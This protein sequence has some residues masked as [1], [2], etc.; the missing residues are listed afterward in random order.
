MALLL[1]KKYRSNKK[2]NSR[3]HAFRD[4]DD[5]FNTF[6]VDHAIIQLYKDHESLRALF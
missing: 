1:T 2:S 5:S 6:S 4:E 3:K